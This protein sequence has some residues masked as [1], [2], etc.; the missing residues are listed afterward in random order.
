MKTINTITTNVNSCARCGLN[1][2][3]LVFEPFLNASG[4]ETHWCLCPESNQPIM[5][6][7]CSIDDMKI[8]SKII[9]WDW[10]EKPNAE[11]IQSAIDSFAGFKTKIYN[12][13]TGS[14]DYAVVVSWAE[15]TS[16]DAQSFYDQN[17]K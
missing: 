2:E 4:S 8:K 12:V 13:E 16:S 11:K 10:K 1:H 17:R 5:L 14:D 6:S 9:S 15:L 3:K 7:Y